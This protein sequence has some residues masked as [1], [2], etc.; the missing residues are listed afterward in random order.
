M[1]FGLARI[2]QLPFV[3]LG[4]ALVLLWSLGFCLV[5]VVGAQRGGRPALK[6]FRIVLWVG[7]AVLAAT[8]LWAV[9]TGQWRLFMSGFGWEPMAEMLVL[10]AMYI[11]TLAWMNMRYI[12][13]RLREEGEA[14]PDA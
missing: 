10:A 9:V 12:S 14:E 5:F 8:W 13:D 7:V 11:F 1:Y 6:F 4:I 2:S 3:P